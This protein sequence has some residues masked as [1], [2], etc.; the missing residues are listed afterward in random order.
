MLTPQIHG[1]FESQQPL[2][3]MTAVKT[4]SLAAIR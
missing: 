1:N 4:N 2:N 3:F